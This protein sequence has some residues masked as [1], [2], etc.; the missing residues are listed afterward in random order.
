LE[1]SFAFCVLAV[2]LLAERAIVTRR[3]ALLLTQAG[4][5]GAIVN[6]QPEWILR[7]RGNA[8][9]RASVL[10]IGL[11]TFLGF[12]GGQAAGPLGLIAGGI[13]G[14]AIPTV[15]HR[16]GAR[17]R[18]EVMERQ[19]AELAE[20]AA[21]AVRSGLSVGQAVEFAHREAEPPM[22]E[23]VGGLVAQQR[24]GTPFDVAVERFGDAIGTDDARLLAVILGVHAKAGGNLAGALDEVTAT[25]RHRVALRRELRALSAQGR[26]SGLILASLPIAFSVVLAATSRAKLAPIYASPA[27][28][29]MVASGLMMEALAFLWIRRLLRVDA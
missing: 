12:I 13:G 17:L 20:S 9:L 23:A 25:I 4:L 3:A 1:T 18:A 21:L 2:L 22:R 27:G 19:L 26:I 29:A 28:M 5:P 10:A 6:G 15:A 16:R 14:A 8:R 24:L 7:A 11:A